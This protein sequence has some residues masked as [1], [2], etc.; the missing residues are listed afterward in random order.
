MGERDEAADDGTGVRRRGAQAVDEHA[1]EL[2][3]VQGEPRKISQVGVA[4]AEVVHG[5][6]HPHAGQCRDRLDGAACRAEQGALGEFELQQVRR[7]PGGLQSARDVV[8][9]VGVVRLADGEVDADEELGTGMRGVPLGT[10]LAG[11]RQ[12]VAS[13]LDDGAGLLG[14]VDE[15]VGAERPERGVHPADERLHAD[16]PAVGEPDDRL[17]LHPELVAFEAGEQGG[18]QGV[19]GH[20]AGMALR[21]EADPPVAPVGLGPVQRDVRGLQDLRGRGLLHRALDHPDAGR[22]DE[23]VL[24]DDDRIGEHGEDGVGEHRQLALGRIVDEDREL[25]AAHPGDQVAPG[26]HPLVQQAGHR[27]Q[28]RV[29]DVVPEPVVDGL[30]PVEVEMADARPGDPVGECGA[31]PVLEEG[32]VGQQGQGVVQRLSPQPFPQ[33]TKG[34][35]VLDQRDDE[36]GHA[37]GV[38]DGR[39][40]EVGPHHVPLAVPV[41]LLHPRAVAFALGDV[42]V[43]L[44]HLRSVVGVDEVAHREQAELLDRVAEHRGEGRVDVD[45]PAFHVDDPDPDAGVGEDGAEAGLAR[46]QRTLHPGVGRDLRAAHRLLLVE[47]PGPQPRDVAV[48][49]RRLHGRRGLVRPVGPRRPR[50]R[51]EVAGQ[52][53]H[54]DRQDVRSEHSRVHHGGTHLTCGVDVH[55]VDGRGACH[56]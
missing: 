31:E 43:E 1:R 56:L 32:A 45:D 49:D 42:A 40:G 15:L 26:G 53:A 9:E 33:L 48:G 7:E 25:V 11:R 5:D 16:R 38:A 4:G 27:D 20:V 6:P 29:A 23:T 44:P 39:G 52:C 55:R 14:E 36:H 35:D 22:D 30:E 46:A 24:V 17:V 34:G 47:D 10:A 41:S 8:D 18:R 13:E 51:G 54:R 50:S 3:G 28:E 19:A 21:V 37:V 12:H 2:Q